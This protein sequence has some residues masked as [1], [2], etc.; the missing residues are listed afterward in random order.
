MSIGRVIQDISSLF[1][2][3]S[4]YH[5]PPEARTLHAEFMADRDRWCRRR[6]GWNLKM[7]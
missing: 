7:A 1:V 5:V 6:S 4:I 2:Y 3:D